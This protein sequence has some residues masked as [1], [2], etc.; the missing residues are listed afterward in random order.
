MYVSILITNN[1]S[2]LSLQLTMI[3][4]M[5]YTITIYKSISKSAFLN[6][7]AEKFLHRTTLTPS[8]RIPQK[9]LKPK[10]ITNAKTNPSVGVA[11]AS[12]AENIVTPI[13]RICEES[14][15]S[16]IICYPE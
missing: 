7:D 8:A 2:V 3:P 13:C 10:A 1:A 9:I 5:T 6:F 15:K 4:Y 11:K 14:N 16:V 12:I